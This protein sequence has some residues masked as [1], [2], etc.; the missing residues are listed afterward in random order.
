[1]ESWPSWI[2]NPFQLNASYYSFLNEVTLN[3]HINLSLL[4]F[5]RGEKVLIVISGDKN[6]KSKSEEDQF[7]LSQWA[8]DNISPQ[9][10]TDLVDGSK[11]FIFSWNQKHRP[12]HEKALLHYFDPD[13][14]GQKFTV[15]QPDS[16]VTSAP[17][18]GP[19]AAPSRHL[20]SQKEVKHKCS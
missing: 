4:F 10:R 2:I 12:I 15:S 17:P 18:R 7:F 3:S 20:D 1:M 8:K 9:F 6:Y 14:S 16:E 5:F 13:K 19:F 11:S